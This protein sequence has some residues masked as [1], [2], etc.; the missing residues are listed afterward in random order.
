MICIELTIDSPDAS[1]AEL[2]GPYESSEEEEV[3]GNITAVEPEHS[4]EELIARARRAGNMNNTDR[5]LAARPKKTKDSGP[6]EK[7]SKRKEPEIDLTKDSGS[8]PK[9]PKKLNSVMFPKEVRPDW[10][11]DDESIDEL[12][13]A[14]ALQTI[15][16]WNM[17]KAMM[18]QNDLTEEKN[19]KSKGSLKK[20]QEIKKIKVKEGEDDAGTVLHSQRFCFRTPLKKPE[21]YWSLV[22]SKWPEVNKKIHL[23]HLGL[24]HVISAKTLE[25]V[26]DKS[27]TN[28]DIKKF[29]N[30]NVMIGREGSQKTS[31]IHQNGDSIELETKDTW[32]EK[33]SMWQ[34]EEA[35]DNL[36]RLWTAVWPGDYGP[37]N[38]R[39]VVTRHRAFNESFDNVDTRKKVTEDFI[40]KVLQDNAVKAGQGLPPLSF[41]EVDKRAKEIVNRKADM[42]RSPELGN[43]STPVRPSLKASKNNSQHDEFKEVRAETQSLSWKGQSLCAW[44]NTSA[45]CQHNRCR[46][47]HVCAKVPRGQK[48]PC[49]ERHSKTSCQKQ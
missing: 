43:T 40:N 41:D 32:L 21:D 17:T 38:L 3:P 28:I 25:M 5:V 11:L 49:G 14:E 20:D 34:L 6:A 15:S 7:L 1:D 18:R 46:H 36:V 13:R 24:D 33:A 4:T 30:V 45:G 26:H 44:F 35:L 29:S 48:E 8:H 23:A 31:K 37:A 9:I 42:M 22:P 47:A 12:T 10:L 2:V 16:Q 39:G 27:D 19:R